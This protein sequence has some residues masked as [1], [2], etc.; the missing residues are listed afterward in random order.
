V[1]IVAAPPTKTLEHGTHAQLD[2]VV[3]KLPVVVDVPMHDVPH[4]THAVGVMIVAV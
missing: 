2:V 3:P 1:L 4:E